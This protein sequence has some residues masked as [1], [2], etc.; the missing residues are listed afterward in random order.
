MAIAL[1]LLGLGSLFA[2][3]PEQTQPAPTPVK[4]VTTTTTTTTT[5]PDIV[6]DDE[7]EIASATQRVA[8]RMATT[9][10]T[11]TLPSGKCEEWFPLAVEVGWPVDRLEKLGRIIW[12]ESRCLPDVSATG[13]FGL[14]QIQYNA[15][16]G[17]LRDEFGV[18]DRTQ[19]YDPELNLRAALWLAGYAE[20]TYGC[21]SQPWYMS[22]DW[23]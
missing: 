12:A 3:T 1:L 9:I 11:T 4:M 20:R 2:D 22:G 23:C 8:S 10:P 16:D 7:K 15:H 5:E 19:L 18:T 17:W 14:T 21:W 6:V 13:S